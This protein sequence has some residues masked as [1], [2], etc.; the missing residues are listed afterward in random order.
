MKKTA[1]RLLAL[2]LTVSLDFER[3]LQQRRYAGADR[4]RK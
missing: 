2:A 4:F 1:S 3:M